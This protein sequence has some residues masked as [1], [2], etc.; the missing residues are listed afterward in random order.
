MPFGCSYCSGEMKN[1]CHPCSSHFVEEERFKLNTKGILG[2]GEGSGEKFSTRYQGG[3]RQ[4]TKNATAKWT[5][6]LRASS[7][8]LI[9]HRRSRYMGGWYEKN[10]AGGKLPATSY[11]ATVSC[12]K[13]GFFWALPGLGGGEVIARIWLLRILLKQNTALLS[14]VRVSVCPSHAWHLSFVTYIK[15]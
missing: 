6:V 8:H 11:S 4:L 2:E 3:C 13:N 9:Q 1:T 10:A 14:T 7:M 5:A 15:A 12:K